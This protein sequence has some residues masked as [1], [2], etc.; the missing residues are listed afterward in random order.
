MG[1]T[2][3]IGLKPVFV[4]VKDLYPMKFKFC[5]AIIIF[6]IYSESIILWLENLALNRDKMIVNIDK[7]CEISTALDSIRIV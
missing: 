6:Y 3:K 1:S 2:L 5:V 7:E 4:D